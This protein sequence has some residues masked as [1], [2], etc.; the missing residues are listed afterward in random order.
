MAV[1]NEFDDDHTL[2]VWVYEY[3]TTVLRLPSVTEKDFEDYVTR[4]IL[5]NTSVP[6]FGRNDELLVMRDGISKYT[7]EEPSNIPT[8]IT[9]KAHY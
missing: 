5:N 9:F 1:V 4:F 6:K 3:M 2:D 7:K 8:F